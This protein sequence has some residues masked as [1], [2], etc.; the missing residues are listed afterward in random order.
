VDDEQLVERVRA[1]LGH[2]VHN[3]SSLEI[4][5]DDGIVTLAG[6]IPR[7][8]LPDALATARKVRGVEQV[9]DELQVS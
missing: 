1:E 9:R 2:K 7:Q 3:T 4:S 8:E 6:R 5:A